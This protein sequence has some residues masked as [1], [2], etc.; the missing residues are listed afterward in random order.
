MEIHLQRVL[1]GKKS[2]RKRFSKC[3]SAAGQAPVLVQV[4]VVVRVRIAVFFAR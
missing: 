1:S 4:L 3:S 2:A